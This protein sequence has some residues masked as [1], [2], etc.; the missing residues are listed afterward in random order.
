MN[1]CIYIKF[2]RAGL[3]YFPSDYLKNNE[4]ICMKFLPEV[5][6][7]PSKNPFIYLTDSLA[8]IMLHNNL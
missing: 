3:F 2:T 1:I 8:Q 7:G 6:L 5:Y 4:R